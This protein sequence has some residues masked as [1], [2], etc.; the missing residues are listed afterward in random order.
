LSYR[1]KVT[2]IFT[3]QGYSTTS[4]RFRQIGAGAGVCISLVGL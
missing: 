4:F 2:D 3:W 1:G